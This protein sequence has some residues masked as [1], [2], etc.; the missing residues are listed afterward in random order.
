MTKPVHNFLSQNLQISYIKLIWYNIQRLK[1][2]LMMKKILTLLCSL[3]LIS[4][5]AL[6]KTD[7][8]TPSKLLNKD[9]LILK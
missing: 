4:N 6:A 2:E 5:L 1:R 3:F 7:L 9:L 8:N